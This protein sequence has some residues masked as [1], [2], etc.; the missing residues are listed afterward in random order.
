MTS[1]TGPRALRPIEQHPGVLVHSSADRQL[2]VEQWLL[3]THAAPDRA[4]MEWQQANVALLPLGTL[5]SAVRIPAPMVV[6]VAG[7][8]DPEA[9]DAFLDQ[10]LDG[11]PV[12]CDPGGRRYYALV[13]GTMPERWRNAAEEWRT[14]GVDCLGRDTYLGVPTVWAV[15]FDPQTMASYWSVP[16]PSAGELCEPLAVARLI[17]AG[18]SRLAERAEA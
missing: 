12:I 10:A 7:S 18:Q 14:L 17:A 16:M 1:N 3:A 4:R 13:P 6:A 8:E 9:L 11:G 5:L 15:G 2:A